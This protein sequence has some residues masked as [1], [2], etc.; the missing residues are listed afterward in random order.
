MYYD[1][2]IVGSIKETIATLFIKNYA[3]YLH[4]TWIGSYQNV[5]AVTNCKELKK[6]GGYEEQ[7]AKS[8]AT[9]FL[10]STLAAANIRHTQLKPQIKVVRLPTLVEFSFPLKAM[11]VDAIYI[12]K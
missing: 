1:Q 6:L 4:F 7:S 8:A 10:K 12:F 3:V 11:G 2:I 9:I 5:A